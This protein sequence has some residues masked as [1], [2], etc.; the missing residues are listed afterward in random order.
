MIAPMKIG[1]GFYTD[2]G[3][4]H[5]IVQVMQDGWYY[6]IV[7]PKDKKICVDWALGPGPSTSPYQEPE[8][9]KYE[10]M[11]TAMSLLGMKDDPHAIF[12]SLR[13]KQFGSEFSGTQ[14]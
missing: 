5:L 10:A 8:D 4:L 12:R 3:D 14:I 13:W 2:L 7:Q 6:R 11:T 9:I 1:E